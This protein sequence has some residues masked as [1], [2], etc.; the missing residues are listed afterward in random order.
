MP[1]ML[2]FLRRSAPIRLVAMVVV[3]FA[4]LIG[5]IVVHH[6]LGVIHA[7]PAATAAATVALCAGMIGV[8][9]LLV[10]LFERRWPGELAPRPGLRWA[11]LGLVLGFVLFCI[12][13]ATLTL[14]G[15]ASW[16][17]FKGFGGVGQALMLAAMAGVGEELVF[18]GVL[19]RIL[20][21]S[22]GTAL[23]IAG[24]ALVFGLLHAVNPGA[25]LVSTLAIALEAGVM[26]AAAYAWSRNLWLPIALHLAWNFTEG[27][28]FG[29]AVSGGH[30]H[31]SLFVVNLAPSASALVTGGP[32]GPEASLVAVAVC[33][34]LG[35]AFIVAARRA[36]RWRGPSWRMMLD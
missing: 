17:G 29:A 8:Y 4:A 24:S 16:A 31:G 11:G 28:V 6:L 13:Y 3:Q 27:G 34:L 2:N 7:P 32:F 30:G 26:L 23:A 1:R 36:G 14:M 33:S 9:A 5:T 22:L 10:R 20:E 25:T 12:V 35:V 21:S 19:F 15:V 18:R